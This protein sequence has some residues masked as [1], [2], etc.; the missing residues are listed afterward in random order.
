M[1][2]TKQIPGK[3]AKAR[4][5]YFVG[6]CATTGTVGQFNERRRSFSTWHVGKVRGRIVSGADGRW[7]FRGPKS[8]LAAA[9]WFLAHCEKVAAS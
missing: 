8:A 7:K 1:R 2:K 3:S 4:A 9:K 6:G 5:A